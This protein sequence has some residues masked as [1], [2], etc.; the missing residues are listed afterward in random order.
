LGARRGTPESGRCCSEEDE[1]L[2]L[3]HAAPRVFG[4]KARPSA[5]LRAEREPDPE[6]NASSRKRRVPR[7]STLIHDD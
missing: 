1:D 6:R 7:R 5:L 3:A 2:S 4:P